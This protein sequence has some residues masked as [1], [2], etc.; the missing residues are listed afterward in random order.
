LQASRDLASFDWL[1]HYTLLEAESFRDPAGNSPAA[2]QQIGHVLSPHADMLCR[3]R[4]AAKHIDQLVEGFAGRSGGIPFSHDAGD[5][6]FAAS[7]SMTK[8]AM[9]LLVFSL[10]LPAKLRTFQRH[11]TCL[12]LNPRRSPMIRPVIQSKG[13]TFPW[14]K[15]LKA[16]SEVRT[17]RKIRPL[18][19]DETGPG[20]WL[21]GDK[22]VYFMPNTTE[23]AQTIVYAGECDPTKLPFDAWWEKKRATFGGVDG[24]EFISLRDIETRAAKF[25]EQHGPPRFFCIVDFTP[26]N[27][28]TGFL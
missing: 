3:S 26:D 15:V 21:V 27:F 12:N 10:I 5:Y 22:D 20:L 19:G 2:T 16:L 18:Y 9:L 11:E 4:L 1:K 14:P 24:I 8:Y 7:A 28:S 6:T 17:A 13:L 23:K 25:Q